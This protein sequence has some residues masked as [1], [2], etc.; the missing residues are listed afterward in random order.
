M[1]SHEDGER[2][3]VAKEAGLHWREGLTDDQRQE[4]NE[5]AK[6]NIAEDI[7]PTKKEPTP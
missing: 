2:D 7:K 4:W 1:K 5:K 3:L 6:E